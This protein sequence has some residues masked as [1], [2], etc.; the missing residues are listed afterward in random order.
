MMARITYNGAISEV[1]GATSRVK[2]GSVLVPTLFCLIL[3]A[4][5]MGVL[6]YVSPTELTGI[7]STTRHELAPTLISLMLS[8]ILMGTYR[9]KRPVYVPPPE[10]VGDFTKTSGCRPPRDYLGPPSTTRS[11]STIAR[12]APRPKK[13]CNG[14]GTSSM[15]GAPT[16]AWL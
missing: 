3:S 13:T 9:D 4:M 15:P 5:L 7:F 2:Q 12:S 8:T 10:L 16:S 14:A 11:S 6:G 1:L